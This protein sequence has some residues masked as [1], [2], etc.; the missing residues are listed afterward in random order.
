MA[1]LG[2]HIEAVEAFAARKQN[3]ILSTKAQVMLAIRETASERSWI[4]RSDSRN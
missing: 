2:Q 3:P 1:F 4:M